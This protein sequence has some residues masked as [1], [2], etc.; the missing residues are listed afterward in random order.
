MKKA[1]SLMV[2]LLLLFSFSG[3][4]DKMTTTDDFINK[5]RKEIPI[6]DA[7]NT[8][9][10]YAGNC[11]RDNK[12]LLWFVSGNENQAHYYLPM[13]CS[14]VG[15]DSY[16]FEQVYKPMD[17]GED[18]AV[19]Q[20]MGGYAFCVNNPNC[21][22]IRILDNSGMTDVEIPDESSYPFIYYNT[23]IPS[24]YYFLDKDGNK[25]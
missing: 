15:G 14:V 4:S 5:A 19:L 11:M 1:F 7:E 12:A 23:I 3:C 24:E 13:G 6:G 10:E 16:V 22:V 20:W 9:I 18:I 25:L 17:R 2:A 8:D 21:T